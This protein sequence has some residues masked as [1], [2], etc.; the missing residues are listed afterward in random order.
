[1][2]AKP[3]ASRLEEK[4]NALD[5]H[6]IHEG[7]QHW[8]DHHGADIPAHLRPKEHSTSA[9]MSGFDSS[10]LSAAIFQ[11]HAHKR[12][13]KD[14]PERQLVRRWFEGIGPLREMSTA[15]GGF[16]ETLNAQDVFLHRAS[17]HVAQQGE[18]IMVKGEPNNSIWIVI[19]GSAELMV[20]P[21]DA[22]QVNMGMDTVA[23]KLRSVC[24]VPMATVSHS[25]PEFLDD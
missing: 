12:R 7:V 22:E 4:L 16:L 6:L 17:T 1:M 11:K 13:M 19:S 8:A 23:I 10:Q 18:D 3:A 21:H 5:Q 2:S 20:S 24:N 25:P 9:Y 14:S 15:K